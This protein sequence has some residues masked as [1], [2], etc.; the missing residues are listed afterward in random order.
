MTALR[1]TYALA[2]VV[3]ML[4]APFVFVGVLNRTKS[5]WSG[6][7]GPPLLQALFDVLRLL[8]KQPVYSTTTTPLFRIA[9]WVLL[10]TSVGS[11]LVVPLL[12]GTPLV[13]F[14]FDFVWFAYVWG[15]G[16]IFVMLA[17]L[18]TGSSFEGMGAAREA[19]FAT[20]IE[21]ALFLVLG[22]LALFVGTDT[23]SHA[24]RLRLDDGPAIAI[25]FASV[26]ALLIVL[27]VEA[28]RLPVDD[29]ATHLELTMVHEVMVLDHSGPDLAAIQTA[30]ACKLYTGATIIAT[31]LNPWAGHDSATAI[32]T[33][34]ALSLA[35]AITLGTI[36]SVIA[37]LK[38]RAVPQYVVVALACGVLAVLAT[39]WRTGG[40]PP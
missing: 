30:A 17:A 29:P 10:V 12:G 31:L 23:L 35:L 20:L 36:E 28:A 7:R 6:R 16:R 21:P 24:L 22:A 39:A 18:D 5:L 34:L 15:L 37:R 32:A 26:V 19:T 2:H 1:L 4:V 11:A 13:S 14:S 3:A 33:Q 27:Q 25:W 8:R 38:L 9:P 40:S